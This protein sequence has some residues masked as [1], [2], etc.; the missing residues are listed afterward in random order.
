MQGRSPSRIL[1]P[2]TQ[3]VFTVDYF[4]TRLRGSYEC[5]RQKG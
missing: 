5:Q 3:T 1:I 4:E 2:Y